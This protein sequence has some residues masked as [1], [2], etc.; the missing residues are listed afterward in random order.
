[1]R[2][3]STLVP[4]SPSIQLHYPRIPLPTSNITSIAPTIKCLAILPMPASGFDMPF[5]DL[6]DCGIITT[7]PPSTANVNQ[8]QNAQSFRA[9][10]QPQN[11]SV[12]EAPLSAVMEKFF[13]SGDLKPLTPTCPPKVLLANYNANHFCAFHQM[14]GHHTDKCYRFRHEIQD[15]I[16]DGMVQVPPKP[17]VISNP[18]PQHGSDPLVGQITINSTHINPSS[19]PVTSILPEREDSLLAAVCATEV[20]TVDIWIDSDEGLAN[21][22]TD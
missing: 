22:R 3:S 9:Q 20:F 10:T 21:E 18:L 2:S 17:N 4:S 8:V 7:P 6:I 14:P 19:K 11:F 1:M 5:Q 16:D 13:Q 12:F 15:L